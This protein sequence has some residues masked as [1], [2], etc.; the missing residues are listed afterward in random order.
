M[1]GQVIKASTA[2]KLL[3]VIF[4]QELRWKD[5]V[6]KAIQRATK[7]CIAIG[8]LRHLRPTQIRQLYRAC[9]NPNTGLCINSMAQPTKR[10]DASSST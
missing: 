5:H 10:Q 3:G 7:T 8:G 2:A 4:N 9:V 1:Q 6:Q